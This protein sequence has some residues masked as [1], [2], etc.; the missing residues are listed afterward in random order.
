MSDPEAEPAPP[1]GVDALR[2]VAESMFRVRAGL[3]HGE[4][5]AARHAAQHLVIALSALPEDR[6]AYEALC[7]EADRQLSTDPDAWVIPGGPS[8]PREA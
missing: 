8:T 4:I 7:E 1:S 2:A 6:A 5:V 3:E